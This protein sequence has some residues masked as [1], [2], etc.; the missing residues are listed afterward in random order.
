MKEIK[1]LSEE[2]FKRF[3]PKN[4]WFDK[5]PLIG[6]HGLSHTLRVMV[7]TYILCQQKKEIR[8]DPFM[9][10]AS[11]HD[12]KRT[13]D[14]RED[15]HGLNAAKW[16]LKNK[17]LFKN[18]NK[19]EINAIV[20]AVSNH[21]VYGEIKLEGKEKIKMFNILKTADAL[22]RFRLK[23]KNWWPN[24]KFIPLKLDKEILNFAKNF[25]IKTEKEISKGKAVLESII[26]MAKKEKV[27][28][29]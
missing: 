23:E 3:I 1:Q 15:E 9:I 27:I 17:S 10:A 21:D 19:K 11:I 2:D 7:Y 22:D 25:S 13:K 24:Q 28:N 16:F 6:I 12:L 14:E 8:I 26:E 29:S 18:I 5:N 20:F 4:E